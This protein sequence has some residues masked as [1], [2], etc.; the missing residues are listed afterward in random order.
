MGLALIFALL[1]S[2]FRLP[3]YYRA[4]TLLKQAETL[5]ESGEDQTAI[6]FFQKVLEL[7][8]TAKRARMGIALAYFRSTDEDDHKRGLLALQG[9]KIA[10]DDWQELVAV[11]PPEY[12]H[13]F[14]RK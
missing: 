13:F 4:A 8:P 6:G 12:Q 9:L 14:T 10:K 7:T 3:L 5:S 11:M 1:I 2:A